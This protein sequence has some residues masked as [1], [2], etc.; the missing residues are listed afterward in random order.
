M[1]YR[2][3]ALDKNV[4][5]IKM[6]DFAR[7]FPD[8]MT[9]DLFNY[10]VA[11]DFN[12]YPV[13]GEGKYDGSYD[14]LKTISNPINSKSIAIVTLHSYADFLDDIWAGKS[15]Y[16]KKSYSYISEYVVCNKKTG[17]IYKSPFDRNVYPPDFK[18]DDS[19]KNKDED[20]VFTDYSID[21]FAEC[22]L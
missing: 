22:A 6:K 11:F 4:E 20:F 17:L 14:E 7:K 2:W 10:N 8:K 13:N 18:F 15:K 5:V 3:D 21:T 19:F 12:E 1:N 16:N 9:I